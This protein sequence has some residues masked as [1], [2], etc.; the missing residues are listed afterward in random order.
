MNTKA[1]SDKGYHFKCCTLFLIF[2]AFPF[3]I[4]F[5][6]SFHSHCFVRAN[7]SPGFARVLKGIAR[8]RER[9]SG[10]LV[11]VIHTWIKR[12]RSGSG[13]GL[14]S[15]PDPNVIVEAFSESVIQT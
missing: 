13:S 12:V 4:A 15:L 6:L 1:A 9:W 10:G 11:R 5:S 3:I 14:F 7:M 2:S 8:E